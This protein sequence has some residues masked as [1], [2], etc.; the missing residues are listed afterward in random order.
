MNMNFGSALETCGHFDF[1]RLR[2]VLEKMDQI[3]MDLNGPGRTPEVHR[4]GQWV[5]F[6]EH[7]EDRPVGRPSGGAHPGDPGGQR[8]GQR[9]G[10][11]L[12][13]PPGPVPTASLEL[14]PHHKF[15]EEKYRELGRDLPAPSFGVPSQGQMDR[16]QAMAESYGI[17]VV[18]YR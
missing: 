7:P 5:D 10:G 12:P 8:G 15:G 4:P 3:F 1:D 6:G 14:L 11:G 17:P 2:P 16:W 13:V 18:S 9:A